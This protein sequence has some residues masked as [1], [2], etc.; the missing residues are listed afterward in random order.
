MKKGKVLGRWLEALGPGLVAGAI[1]RYSITTAFFWYFLLIG[2][3][4][5]VL[6][7]WLV[8]SK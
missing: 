7:T 2:V 4:V 3:I 5:T 1:V 8:G 6:G